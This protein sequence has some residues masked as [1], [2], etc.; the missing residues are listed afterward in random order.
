[1][2]SGTTRIWSRPD[3]GTWRWS[4]YGQIR[5]PFFDVAH[6]SNNGLLP[7]VSVKEMDA[8]VAEA[9]YRDGVMSTVVEFVN[10]TRTL[11]GLEGTDAAGTN[12]DCV[13]KL[14]NG[15]CGDLWEMFK[16]EKRI[17][18]QFQGPTRVGW[19]YDGRGWGDLMEGTIMQL[20]VPY[21]EMQLLQAQPYDYG[22]VG[23]NFGAPVGT[24]GY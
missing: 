9:A 1:V 20:P 5:Q 12:T 6:A 24:Y 13:P 7:M 18:T 14:P 4:Y 15:S 19:W 11:H 22:G 17:E 10:S 8:L 16:W 3:R 21:R 2:N 23:G